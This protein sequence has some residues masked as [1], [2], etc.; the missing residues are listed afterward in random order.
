V[1]SG[2]KRILCPIDFD[3]NAIE[4]LVLAA[5]LARQS[6]ATVILLHIVPFVMPP[7]YAPSNV[8]TSDVQQESA[9]KRLQEVAQRH[10]MNFDDQAR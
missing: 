9:R 7:S 6:D 10:L 2:F 4:A 1:A 5:Q 3:E 8:Y